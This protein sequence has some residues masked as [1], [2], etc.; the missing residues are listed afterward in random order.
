[1]KQD[2]ILKR[3]VLQLDGNVTT[4]AVLKIDVNL[5]KNYVKIPY[6][7]IQLHF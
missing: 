7:L 5:L 6:L 3:R 1:M 4:A 2:K